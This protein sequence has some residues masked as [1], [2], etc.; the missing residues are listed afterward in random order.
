[1]EYKSF[2]PLINKRLHVKSVR[3]FKNRKLN[4]ITFCKNSTKKHSIST[5]FDFKDKKRQKQLL[6][7][8]KYQKKMNPQTFI[9]PKQIASNCW[10]NTMFVSFFFS[11]KGI[12]FFRFFRELM[13][14]G[15]TIDGNSIPYNIHRLLFIFNLFIES[16]YNYKENQYNNILLKLGI[17]NRNTNFFIVEL[18]NIINNISSTHNKDRVLYSDIPNIN[19]AGNPLY[20]Y[21]SIMKYLKYNILK[22]QIF[23][24]NIELSKIKI[25]KYLTNKLLGLKDIPDILIFED[26]ESKSNYSNTIEVRHNDKVLKWQVDSIIITNRDFY[27]KNSNKHFTSLLTCNSIPYKFDGYSKT[28]LSKFNWKSL[29]ENNTDKDW[30]FNENSKYYPEKYNM[31]YGYKILFYYRIL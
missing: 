17:K 3:S 1:M 18:F 7:N 19:D 29:L 4:T 28:R 13:I 30:T 11:D 2:S 24:I 6:D 20:Y 27:E 5:C 22:I 25:N 26:Y 16:S 12:K 10:F 9:A 23:K 8:L 14:I 15:K 21:L 31:T